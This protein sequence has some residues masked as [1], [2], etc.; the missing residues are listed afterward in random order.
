MTSEVLVASFLSPSEQVK[1]VLETLATPGPSEPPAA[2]DILDS[3]FSLQDT[4]I[5]AVI[6]HI[7]EWN[8]S[9]EGCVFVC[10]YKNSNNGAPKNLHI[11]RSFRIFGRFSIS[12]AQTRRMTLDLRSDAAQS[13]SNQPRTGFSVTIDDGDNSTHPLTFFT[14]DV[15]KLQL[16]IQECKRLK[17]I[18]DSPE[19]TKKSQLTSEF[20][21]MAPYLNEL[22]S[23]SELLSDVPMDL[24]IVNGPLLDR[25]SPSSAGFPGDDVADLRL[26]RDFWIRG[27]AQEL[28]LKGAYSMSIRIGTFNVNGRLPSQDLSTWVGGSTTIENELSSLSIYDDKTLDA[29]PVAKSVLTTMT[30]EGTSGPVISLGCASGDSDSG[31]DLLVLGFQ[32]LDH[33]AEAYIYSTNVAREEAWITAV[34]AALGEKGPH[35]EKLAS[36]QLVGMFIVIFVKKSVK[37]YFTDVKTCAAGAGLM[38]VMGNKGATAIRVTFSPK[39]DNQLGVKTPNSTVL[40]FVNA[41]LAAFDEM[42]DRRNTDYQDLSK[43]LTFETNARLPEEAEEDI[44][45]LLPWLGLFNSD[46]LF[47]LGDLNYRIDLPDIDIREI[48]CSEEWVN[49]YELLHQHD[50]L[51]KARRTGKAFK[52]FHEANIRFPPTYRFTPGIL[53]DGYSSKRKPAWTDRILSLAGSSAQIRQLS[54]TSDPQITM[55]DH[56]PVTANFEINIGFW[57]TQEYQLVIYKL[58][59]EVRHM[60]ETVGRTPL[61]VLTPSI[62]FGKVRYMQPSIR[63]VKVQNNGNLP[64]AYRFVPIH[65]EGSIHPPW[66]HI[67]PMIGIVHPNGIAEITFT[68]LVDNSTAPMLNLA[69]KILK[70]AVILHSMLGKDHFISITGEYQ[71]TCFSTSLTRLTRLT[72]PAR[73]LQ[74]CHDYLPD[75][76]A[77]N[78]PREVMRLVNWMMAGSARVDNLFLAPA[79]DVYI[80]TI[81][82]CLDTGDEFPY[83]PS[84]EDDRVHLAFGVALLTFLNSLTQPVI[85]VSLHERFLEAQDRDDAFELLN[86]LA[87][88]S[89]NT[90]ICITAFLHYICRSSEDPAFKARRLASIFA[91]I[92]IREERVNVEIPVSLVDKRRFLLYFID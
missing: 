66:L 17:E 27:K 70:G 80:G 22:N 30:R 21:W 51:I 88:S 6:S 76:H 39:A 28:S 32:E 33:S 46:A 85:P 59:S 2:V 64:A 73:T 58:M 5:L 38:G 56:R 90:W 63:N 35:Y 11:Q 10:R 8:L 49:K 72:G 26:I 61:K 71:Y 74:S 65:G 87:P 20:Q 67:E 15:K 82:E 44:D 7:D 55:S 23:L 12:M 24:R 50:Q 52:Y 18:F 53:K 81:R 1:A 43:R 13:T 62:D 19:K 84:S 45:T 37:F 31:P 60:E 69:E 34:I 36:R 91:P 78:A 40:T 16:F 47:W 48:A 83:P 92:L 4:R 42:F 79:D 41:H 3:R 89:V 86:A 57:D 54:Y 14:N 68:I 25:L 29:K 9:E 75:G 77:K